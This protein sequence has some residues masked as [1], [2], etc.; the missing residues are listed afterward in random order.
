MYCRVKIMVLFTITFFLNLLYSSP[1]VGVL[2]YNKKR[3]VV[4]YNGPLPKK[5]CA[6][7]PRHAFSC[8]GDCG[9]KFEDW[10]IKPSNSIV[11]FSLSV[12]Y[13]LLYAQE[14]LFICV[15]HSNVSTSQIPGIVF[16]NFFVI[17]VIM[18]KICSS[19]VQSY[20]F[21]IQ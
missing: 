16:Q 3:F 8:V 5:Y 17:L 13:V 6:P 12:K 14:F 11:I 19:W 1:F 18:W 9:L 10:K 21:C 15:I 2:W 4:W 7:W 20:I